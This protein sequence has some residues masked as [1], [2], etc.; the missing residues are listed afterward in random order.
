MLIDQKNTNPQETLE[1]KLN[2][3]MEMFSFSSSI[4]LFEESKMVT[5]SNFLKQP[6]LI[7]IYLMK[8][9]VFQLVY[10]VIGKLL[11]IYLLE[12]LIN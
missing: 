8:T 7:L 9:I 4:K 12:L 10:L 1:I 6:T 3:Q 11:T 2:R 5:S